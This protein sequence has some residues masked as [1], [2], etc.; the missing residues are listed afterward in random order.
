M[1]SRLES[2]GPLLGICLG[3]QLIAR[4]LGAHVYPLGLSGLKL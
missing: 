3:A 4:S 1:R 2:A